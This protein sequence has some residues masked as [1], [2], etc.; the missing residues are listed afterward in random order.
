MREDAHTSWPPQELIDS[1]LGN[2]DFDLRP[3]ETLDAGDSE[4]AQ[5]AARKF[6][7]TLARYGSGVTVITSMSDGKPV[8]MTCQSFSSVSLSPPLVTFLPTKTSRAWKQIQK[9]G[10]FA[11]NFLADGQDGLSNQMASSRIPDKFEGVE[12]TKSAGG[13]P[14]FPGIVGYVDCTVHA[15]HEAGDHFIVVGRV[16]D[17]DF[18]VDENGQSPDPLLFFQGA[19]RTV[20]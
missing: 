16:N 15:V 5:A 14:L 11:V 1:F 7:D 12:W 17:L 9:A 3:G 8:G 10:H 20:R 6:R 18:T 19:Y 4:A 2:F 13:A